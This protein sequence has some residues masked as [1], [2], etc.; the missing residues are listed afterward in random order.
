M[1]SRLHGHFCAVAVASDHGRLGYLLAMSASDPSD[2]V[3]V[4][5]LASTFRGRRLKAQD[6]L[7]SYL[8][9]AIRMTGAR[10]ILFTSVPNSTAERSVRS[11]A[12]RIFSATPQMTQ[13]LPGLA[14][15]KE[16]EYTI[17]L[18]VSGRE[19]ANKH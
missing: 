3:F 8:K 11:L 5:Q 13:H 2:A 1:L 6:Q 18:T 15:Q 14:S 17:T 9:K 10:R 19:K 16:R 4:W 12:K 7:A